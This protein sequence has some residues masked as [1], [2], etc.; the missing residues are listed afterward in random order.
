[1]N[2][3][4]EEQSTITIQEIKYEIEG[5][6]VYDSDT[7]TKMG[8]LDTTKSLGISW[9]KTAFAEVHMNNITKLMDE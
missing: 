1:M 6:D 8:K 3:S 2:N 7:G 4:D 5:E 9:I